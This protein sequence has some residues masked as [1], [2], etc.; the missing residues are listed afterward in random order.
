MSSEWTHPFDRVPGSP[1]PPRSRHL[2]AQ[3]LQ[4]TLLRDSPKHR[5]IPNIAQMTRKS[6]SQASPARDLHEYLCFSAWAWVGHGLSTLFH[7]VACSFLLRLL[8]RHCYPM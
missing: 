5:L 6:R 2:S 7:T 8:S 4:E 3:T 1:R